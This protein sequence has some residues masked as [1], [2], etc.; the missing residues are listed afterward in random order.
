GDR[1]TDAA[2]GIADDRRIDPDQTSLAVDQRSAAVARVHRDVALHKV[3]VTGSRLGGAMYTTEDAER[4]RVIQ[5]EG[6]ADGPDRRTH[7]RRVAVAPLDRQQA[8]RIDAQEC[9]VRQRIAPYDR[10]LDAA[11]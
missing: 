8:W 4:H 9:Q 7:L 3:L 10:G 6:A 1:E 11:A 2:I 5:A